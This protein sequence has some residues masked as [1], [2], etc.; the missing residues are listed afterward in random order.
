MLKVGDA[1]PE[2]TLV[3]DTGPVQLRERIGKALVIYFYPKDETYGCTKEACS[4]RDS[5]EDFVSAGADVIGVSRDDASSH[6]GFK[7]HHR[8]P[9]TLLTDPDGKVAAAWGV[10]GSLGLP[11][12]V[13]FVFD[14][15][16]TVRHRFDSQ[17][18][19]GKHVDEALAIVKQ[20]T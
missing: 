12:R 1:M 6:A 9:F 3:S 4:F 18:R 17:I 14:K 20:L 15:A 16:G 7:Q 5:Y 10:R 19:F 8:L 13:T 11:G 2:T